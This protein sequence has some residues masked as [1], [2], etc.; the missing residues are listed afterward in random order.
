MPLISPRNLKNKKTVTPYITKVS[1]KKRDLLE[2]MAHPFSL[3]NEEYLAATSRHL[4]LSSFPMCILVRLSNFNKMIFFCNHHI[5]GDKI[6]N[7]IFS[8]AQKSKNSVNF[9]HLWV[10][11]AKVFVK[12]FE[13]MIITA[14]FVLMIL[15]QKHPKIQNECSNRRRILRRG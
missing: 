11:I 9:G 8:K 13:T 1:L 14:G 4:F 6:T 5:A 12:E 7:D 10:F 2:K 3:Q 15:F